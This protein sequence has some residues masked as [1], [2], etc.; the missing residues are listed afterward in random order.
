M[1]SGC[2]TTKRKGTFR[3]WLTNPVRKLSKDKLSSSST[4][5]DNKSVPVSVQNSNVVSCAS[6]LNQIKTL[7]NTSDTSQSSIHP[8]QLSSSKNLAH[9]HK[10]HQHHPK[11]NSCS[12]SESTIAAGKCESL[13]FKSRSLDLIDNEEQLECILKEQNDRNIECCPCC[14]CTCN[15]AEC[16]NDS[17]DKNKENKQEMTS[18]SKQQ[19]AAVLPPIPI[20]EEE[21]ERARVKRKYVIQELVDTERDYVRDL[22]L[23]VDGYMACLRN[24]IQH[25]LQQQQN[26]SINVQQSGQQSIDDQNNSNA[27]TLAISTIQV[28]EGLC[29]GKDKIIFGNIETIYF[30]HRE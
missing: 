14:Y 7:T 8:S 13:H 5:S 25:Q 11:C 23:V 30:W 17:S 6:D 16:I 10:N 28:P 27:T 3:K 1:Q 12:S 21:K 24:S 9:H 15:E 18:I 19:T 2:N 26:S 4:T 20:S 29:H 22:G